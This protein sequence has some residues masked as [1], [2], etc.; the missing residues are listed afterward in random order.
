[1][2]TAAWRRHDRN[3]ARVGDEHGVPI[4]PVGAG[5]VPA[6]DRGP[7]RSPRRR[8][9]SHVRGRAQGHAPTRSGVR[10]LCDGTVRVN[11]VNRAPSDDRR[12]RADHASAS[13]RGSA[14]KNVDAVVWPRSP[15]RATRSNRAPAQRRGFPLVHRAPFRIG[16]ARIVRH[17]GSRCVGHLPPPDH[18][19]G[20]GRWF[21]SRVGPQGFAGRHRCRALGARPLGPSWM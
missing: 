12:R 21:P 10:W 13:P 2:R 20:I 3:R 5:L 17:C 16:P 18:W 6:H 8:A 9:P 1:M 11:R 4:Q 19:L 14:T 7:R 15:R